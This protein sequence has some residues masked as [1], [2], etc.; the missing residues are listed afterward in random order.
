MARIL[1]VDDEPKLRALLSMALSAEG[2]DVVEAES[3]EAALHAL[4]RGDGFSTMITDV[5]MPGMSGLDL[6]K[7]ARQEHPGMECIVMT[8]Y[9][10][11][12]TGVEAMRNGALEYV[13]KPFEMDEMLLLVRSAVEKGR[14]RE[15]VAELR[16]LESGRYRLERIIG[17]SKPMQDVIRQAK[18]VAARDTTVLV[19]GK[20]GT[21]KELIAR[22]IH[23]ESGRESFVAINCGALPEN[24]LESEL[25]G[26]E[27]GSFTGANV[28][29]AGYFERAGNGTLF[30][31]EIGD[32]SIAM[33]VKL[34]RVLQ[35]REF[36]RVG[37]TRVIR[38]LARVIAATHRNLEEE[39]KKGI[40]RED[41]Y[42]RL[43]V[44]PIFVPSLSE[45]MDDV[46]ALADAFL[47][48][49]GHQAGVAEGVMSRL[50][51]YSWPG[52]VRELENCLERAAIV[53]SGLPLEIDHLP[54]HIRHKRVLERPSAFRLPET[55]LS[56]DE[57]EKSLLLQALD[58]T[59]GNKTKA[60]A[61]LGITRRAL[62]SKMHTHGVRGYGAEETPE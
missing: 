51:E 22:G 23:A 17:D 58:M 10:D 30:L 20:S 38:T 39:V 46:P 28:Q 60:A 14:L 16:V 56:L 36:T 7:R 48:R 35:E 29:K 42:F 1:V 18:L 4:G 15:E 57:L 53:A 62:Y 19:R 44:F 27:R 24:L 41:L 33:Q 55:G 26:H 6:V 45:R 47:R 40:F 13:T 52:N 11:G 43:N 25:F 49:F 59:S 3:A 2:M 61:L 32:I 31:D 5:R 50:L 8:A 9:G 54:E 37:G 21:G 12:G 34:L